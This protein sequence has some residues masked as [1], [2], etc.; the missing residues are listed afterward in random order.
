[1][2]SR[3]S[4]DEAR[5]QLTV[6]LVALFLLLVQF[7]VVVTTLTRGGPQAFDY[8]F[9]LFPSDIV[10]VPLIV[11]TAPDIVRRLRDRTL[12]R[13]AAVALA[14]VAVMTAAFVVHPSVRGAGTLLRLTGVVAV[15]FVI[16]TAAT[17]VERRVVFGAFALWAT[18]QCGLA[19]AQRATGHH[20]GLGPLGEFP[21]P[22]YD[23]GAVK[24]P[25]GTMVHPYLLAG[26]A[27][28]AGGVLTW[29][30][31][32]DRHRVWVIATA[33]AVAPVALTYSRAAA[34]SCAILLVGVA[35]DAAMAHERR[36]WLTLAALT[37][38]IVIPLAFS[39]AGWTERAHDS[40]GASVDSGRSH[41]I[42]QSLHLLREYPLLGVGPGRY[43]IVL[44]A[45]HTDP[46][47]SGGVLKPVH[48][49]ALLA[50]TEGGVVAGALIVF[51]YVVLG[52]RSW[53]AGPLVFTVFAL[54]VPITMLDHFAYTFPQGLAM[55]AVWIGV[56]DLAAIERAPLTRPLS[57]RA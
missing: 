7:P 50:A 56:L 16:A 29:M 45:E 46:R 19:V 44:H 25:Q 9:P 33:I 43:V 38:G 34:V 10:L 3:P 5:R 32:S 12:P 8:Q 27:V 11:L 54:Y 49:V 26:L 47:P 21:S 30:Y 55:T 35:V 17:R 42:H 57:A 15:A 40:T 36:R 20:L 51:L 23:F 14:I 18:L 31:I 1:M 13:G 37:A 2:A 22:F 39:T 4:G 24:A 52:W 6:I 41:L 48:N 28:L 53:R